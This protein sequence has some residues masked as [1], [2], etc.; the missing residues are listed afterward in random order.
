MA[1]EKKKKKKKSKLKFIIIAAVLGVLAIVALVY[2]GSVLK[3]KK[4][5]Q[6]LVDGVTEETFRSTQAS[7]VYDINK[8]EFTS[9]KGIKELYYIS[10]EQIPQILKQTFIAIE[11]KD[12]YNHSG[13]D[14]WAILRASFTNITESEIKQGASTITQQLAKNMFLTQDVTWERKIKEMF[15]AFELEK[16]FTKEQILEF[17]INNIYFANGY[18]GIEAASQGYFGKSVS[19]L[20]ISQMALLAGIPRRPYDYDP[21]AHYDKAIERRNLVLKQMYADGI[22]SNLEYFEAFNEKIEI[23]GK[24]GY[25]YNYIETYAMYCATQALM[26]ANGF[27]F[28]YSFADD[29][30]KEEYDALY[31]YTYAEYQKSLFTGGYRIYTAIDLEKQEI[32]QDTIDK[33]TQSFTDVNDEGIYKFQAAGVCIDNAS[34]LVT[35][36][37]GGRHQEYEGYTLNRA[38]QSFRQPGSAIKPILDYAPYME[39]GHNP[40]EKIDDSVMLDGPTNNQNIYHGIISLTEALG[41][42]SNVCA[43]KILQDITPAYGMEFLHKMN[44]KKIY[45]DDN[46]QAV[47]IGGFTYGVSPVEMASAYATLENDGIYRNPTCISKITDSAGN[48]IMDYTENKTEVYTPIAARKVTKMMETCVNSGMLGKA[49]LEDAIVAAKSGTTNDCKDGWFC[50]YSKYYTT[51]IWM[52]CDMPEVVPTLSGST[53]PLDAWSEYMTIIHKGLELREFPDYEGM[54]LD[55]GGHVIPKPPETATTRR[56]GLGDN[57]VYINEGANDGN[58]DV[59]G[60][61]DRDAE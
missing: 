56:G 18:Y 5:A 33:N 37:V 55:D 50:G 19:D 41:Y 59:S 45:M 22:I 32:L 7:A 11:D 1:E 27:N 44:F 36:I 43:W 40:D 15:V 61:G 58:V 30:E 31:S 13:I 49:K 51:A 57:E 8:K 9:F 14:I 20:T 24:K 17:Y 23:N 26:E 46:L 16:N 60:M 34:G 38:Y 28:K 47:S 52:G 53:Y 10:D 4:E 35:A 54:I 6:S 3:L 2:L 39:R 48:V 29:A 42:S 12:F 21:I 25:T